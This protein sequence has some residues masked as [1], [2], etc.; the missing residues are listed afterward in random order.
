[1]EIYS[2]KDKELFSKAIPKVIEKA[3]DQRLDKLEPYGKEM[4][5]VFNIIKEY[6]LEHKRIIYGG[7]AQNEFIKIKDKRDAIYTHNEFHDIEFYSPE[8]LHDLIR[9]CNILHEKKYEHVSGKEAEHKETYT[10]FVNFIGYCDITYMPKMI[11]NKMPTLTINRF[12]LVHPHFAMVDF[13][14]MFTDPLLSF[15]RLDKTVDRFFTMQKHY[16]FTKVNKK[17]T[18]KPFPKPK[19]LEGVLRFLT[20]RE[21]TIVVGFYAYNHYLEESKY[22]NFQ[23]QKVE[24]YEIIT[25][26]FVED[27]K[28]LFAYLKSEFPED[29]KDISIVEYQ[30][31]FQF[32]GRSAIYYYKDVPI[33]TLYDNRKRCFPIQKVKVKTFTYKSK[34]SPDSWI[35]IGPYQLTLLMALIGLMKTYVF[36]KRHEKEMLQAF[37]TNLLT[38][39]NY[40]LKTS[41]KTI[42]DSSLFQEF[43]VECVGDTILPSRAKRLLIEK[44]KGKRMAYTYTYYPATDTFRDPKDI[45]YKFANTSGNVVKSSKDFKINPF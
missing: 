5:E 38:I 40:Y 28:E 2:L 12:K 19:I 16:P 43:I 36:N 10:I 3:W 34:I 33:L 18:M 29:G 35:Q 45:T 17:I 24:Y 26:R 37:L 7:Y 13:Y 22:S 41:K 20:Q 11:Y 27:G 14:R 1:M 23:Y 32:T 31:F 25:T 30:P 8:P 39:R 42:F 6:I 21:T 44:R 4:G 15:W 9:L